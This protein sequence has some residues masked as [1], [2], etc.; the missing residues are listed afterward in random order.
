MSSPTPP[1]APPNL[2]LSIGRGHYTDE[3]E[4]CDEGY[5]LF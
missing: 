5:A 4:L 2:S 1:G 3:D